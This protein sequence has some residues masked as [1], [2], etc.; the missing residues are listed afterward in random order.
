MKGDEERGR[1]AAHIQNLSHKIEREG[2]TWEKNAQ[3][4]NNNNN[5]LNLR[6]K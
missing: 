6:K 4:D 2:T 1:R 3:R 5:K